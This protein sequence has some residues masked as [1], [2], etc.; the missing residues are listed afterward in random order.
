MSWYRD[1]KW[2]NYGDKW[3]WEPANDPTHE[4]LSTSSSRRYYMAHRSAPYPASDDYEQY[5]W[6]KSC[7]RPDGEWYSGYHRQDGQQQIG[8]S[9]YYGDSHRPWYD[10]R[11]AP[12]WWGQSRQWEEHPRGQRQDAAIHREEYHAQSTKH[13]GDAKDNWYGYDKEWYRQNKQGT[14]DTFSIDAL[15]ATVKSK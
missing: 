6:G 5:D 10:D 12:Q 8:Q 7:A 15:F 9:S 3:D 14:P 4:E 1:D 13:W 2:Q 11:L